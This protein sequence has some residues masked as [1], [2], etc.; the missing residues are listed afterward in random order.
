IRTFILRLFPGNLTTNPRRDGP[1]LAQAASIRVSRGQSLSARPGGARFK[2]CSAREA[3]REAGGV[4]MV[5]QWRIVG[6][7]LE[8][9]YARAA[10]RLGERAP[11]PGRAAAPRRMDRR[12]GATASGASRPEARATSP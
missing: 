10:E 5:G 8:A 3:E 2:L 1:V 12:F 11:L 6:D 4:R 7:T 9:L